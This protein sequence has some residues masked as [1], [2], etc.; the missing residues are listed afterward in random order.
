MCLKPIFSHKLPNECVKNTHIFVN[1][2][3]CVICEITHVWKKTHICWYILRHR[4]YLHQ[5]VCLKTIFTHKLPKQ[6]VKNT[7]IFLNFDVCVIC[8]ITHVW[9]KTHIC[10]YILRHRV[11]LHQWVCLK[12]I[13][14]HKLP[15]QRVKNTHIFLN[16]DVCVVCEITHV[17]KETR[18]CWYFLCLRSFSYEEACFNHATTL[19]MFGICVINRHVRAVLNTLVCL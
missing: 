17:W 5:W 4:V 16:F 11:Y 15:K 10:W 14:T 3:V 12:T 9:K 2:D 13:F 1:F 8:E 18:K 6:R 19:K 7:H